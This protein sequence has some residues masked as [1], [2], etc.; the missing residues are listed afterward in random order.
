MCSNF[1]LGYLRRL[2]LIQRGIEEDN[3]TNMRSESVERILMIKTISDDAGR[4]LRTRRTVYDMSPSFFS[5]S[6]FRGFGGSGR[7][8]LITELVRIY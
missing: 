5:V 3:N 1:P 8:R 7:G 4:M 6:F 2:R